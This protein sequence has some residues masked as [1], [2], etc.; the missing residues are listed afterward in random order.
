[1]A[2]RELEACLGVSL[3]PVRIKRLRNISSLRMVGALGKITE[4][5]VW[6]N[7]WGRKGVDHFDGNYERA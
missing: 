5:R 7:T 2:G 4:T 6:R 1:M 3:H